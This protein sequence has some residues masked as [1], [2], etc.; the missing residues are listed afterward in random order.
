MRLIGYHQGDAVHVGRRL[1]DG[2]IEPLGDVLSFWRDPYPAVSKA[3]GGVPLKQDDLRLAPPVPPSARVL[4]VG[5]N[6]RAHVDEGPFTVPDHPTIFGRWTQSLSVDGTPV[7]V[8]VDE[9]GLDWEV[10]LAAVIGRPLRMADEAEALDGVFAYATFNDITARRAQKLTTQWTLGK[11]ADNSGPLGDLV[12]ADEVGD[13]NAGLRVT[14]KI[15]GKITQDGSTDQMIFSV[16]AI[17]SF[18]S[19]TFTLR[20][21]DVIATGTPSGVGYARTPPWLLH[22]GDVVEVEVEKLGSVRT[23]VINAENAEDSHE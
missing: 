10:E 3:S 9:D 12:T 16:G 23:P 8:P 2:L 11:N 14:T 22:D 5:L 21:G 18:I 20:P 1:D 4:C 7:S 19:R 13:P 15:N 17:L 6:Y